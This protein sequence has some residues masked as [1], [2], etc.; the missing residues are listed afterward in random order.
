MQGRAAG[1]LRWRQVS[2]SRDWVVTF[3]AKGIAPGN[4]P[5]AHPAAP[6]GSVLEDC[7]LGVMRA[8]GFVPAGGGE[9]GRNSP[10]VKPDCPV[11]GS[12]HWGGFAEGAGADGWSLWDRLA[13]LSKLSAACWISRKPACRIPARAM[14]T[15]SQPG[16]TGRERTASRNLRFTLFLVTALPILLLTTKQKRLCSRPL[17]KY[18]S[19]KRRLAVLLP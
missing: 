6:D 11:N 13:R 15:A 16:A 18:R 10:L 19:T 9:T 1:T 3:A 17:D 12:S 4:A 14:N 5:Q 2:N 8:G 7:F